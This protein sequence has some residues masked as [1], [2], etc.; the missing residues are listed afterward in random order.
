VIEGEQIA[1]VVDQR[2]AR[3]S[4]TRL[5]GSHS[6]RAEI[7][8]GA[9]RVRKPP[10]RAARPLIAEL[11]RPGAQRVVGVPRARHESRRGRSGMP[12]RMVMSAWVNPLARRRD[13]GER[14]GSRAAHP[15]GDR[16]Q[17]RGD[18]QI[19]SMT[20]AT[21]LPPRGQTGPPGL[22]HG[23]ARYP[24]NR[25]HLARDPGTL[26]GVVERGCSGRGKSQGAA[27]SE[28][29]RFA[30]MSARGLARTR[31]QAASREDSRRSWVGAETGGNRARLAQ[32]ARW[33]G[34]GRPR[35]AASPASGSPVVD[36]RDQGGRC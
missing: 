11:P 16:K 4:R 27:G 13:S 35:W 30:E 32:G 22:A 5:T 33:T 28:R 25:L 19:I 10:R 26:R 2:A 7:S 9:V 18:R 3:A 31:L 17:R 34:A 24:Q 36:T 14:A 21:G 1:A 23:N 8:R 12:Q 6:R 15:G 29:S 20:P